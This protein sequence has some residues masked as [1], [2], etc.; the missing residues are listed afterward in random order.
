MAI[1]SAALKDLHDALLD[2]KTS[3]KFVVPTEKHFHKVDTTLV[4]QRM[5]SIL[6][7]LVKY[8]LKAWG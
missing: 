7:L 2:F 4:P 5:T 3:K 1:G 6:I 8:I